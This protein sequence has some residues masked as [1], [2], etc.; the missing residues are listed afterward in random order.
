[1][2]LC[3]VG[4]GR[5]GLPIA[6]CYA[7]RGFSVVGIDSDPTCREAI[8]SGTIPG[9]EPGLKDL[10]EAYPFPIGD[11]IA[12]AVLESDITLVIVSTPANPIGSLALDDVKV[13]TSSIG[14]A[15]RDKETY[16]LVVLISTV[17]P[18]TCRRVLIPLLEKISGKSQGKDFGF[19][20]CPEFLALGETI[21]TIFSPNFILIGKTDD[22]SEL[23]MRA[24]YGKFFGGLS[25]PR[26]VADTLENVE[27][28]KMAL[29]AYVTTKIVF[30][31]MLAL[32][33]EDYAGAHV[34][35]VTEIMS[36]DP[37]VSPKSFRAGGLAGGFCFPRDTKALATLLPGHALLS[38]VCTE[39]ANA[40][41]NVITRMLNTISPRFERVGLLGLSY[42][43]GVESSVQSFGMALAYYLPYN[44]SVIAHDPYVTEVPRSVELVSTPL[45]VIRRS[46]IVILAMP[47]PQ[48]KSL[49]SECET[50]IVI[51]PWRF[52]EHSEFDR[53]VRYIP[54][55]IGIC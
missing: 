48:Y 27:I 28:A 7:S 42:K 2:K 34:D 47:W 19:C 44:Y 11:N 40:A 54:L 33:C 3:V 23:T 45:E 14:L 46:E 52:W 32:L 26:I 5:L 31:N 15:L 36:L 24:V 21:R 39:N 29:N 18:G 30:A 20:Y 55:G 4:L 25:T 41:R 8:L 35:R 51:D 17:T 16:H 38:S 1:M 13:V 50:H 37:R 9:I 22:R 10:L 12:R 53:R 49:A 6:A 43:P